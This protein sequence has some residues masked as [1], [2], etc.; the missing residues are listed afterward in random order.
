MIFYS[1]L[2]LTQCASCKIT[3]PPLAC[4]RRPAVDRQPRRRAPTIRQAGGRDLRRRGLAPHR[5]ENA[6]GEPRQLLPLRRRSDHERADPSRDVADARHGERLQ[7]REPNQA[8][9]QRELGE[10]DDAEAQGQAR[11]DEVERAL[12]AALQL[13]GVAALG[14]A[15]A[16]DVE[17]SS[18][19]S[20]RRSR[21]GESATA[22]SPPP[23]AS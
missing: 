7:H 12:A 17:Q 13:V 20:A 3:T 9:E 16:E 22:R 11:A 10:A 15:R 8:P 23:N 18:S 5:V 21:R 19:R 14:G 2:A 4:A 1:A 6:G